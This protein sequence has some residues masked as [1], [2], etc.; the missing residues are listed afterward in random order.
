MSARALGLA[1]WCTGLNAKLFLSSI[2]RR[3]EVL[4]GVVVLNTV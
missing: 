2:V 4:A 1:Q 3:P